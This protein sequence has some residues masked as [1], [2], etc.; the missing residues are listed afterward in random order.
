VCWRER[1]L[2]GYFRGDSERPMLAGKRPPV[3][4]RFCTAMLEKQTTALPIQ[5]SHLGL[6][7]DLQRVVDL[8][9]EYRTVLPSFVCPRSS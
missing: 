4:R 9:A 7:R 6:F 2:T 3:G 5:R 1:P 8:Y